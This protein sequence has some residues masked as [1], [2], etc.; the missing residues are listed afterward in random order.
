MHIAHAVATIAF[1]RHLTTKPAPTDLEATI[2]AVMYDPDY[3][4]IR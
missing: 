3:R 4:D 1:E 2:R